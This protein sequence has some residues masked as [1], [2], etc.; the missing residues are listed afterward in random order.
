MAPP[1][2]DE[3]E[4][5]EDHVDKHSAPGHH[6]QCSNKAIWLFLSGFD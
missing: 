5:E 4:L 6:G 2:S 1:F 3:M